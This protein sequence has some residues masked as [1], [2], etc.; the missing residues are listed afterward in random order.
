MNDSL[1][2]KLPK[3]GADNYAEWL[4]PMSAHLRAKKVFRLVSGEKPCPTKDDDK[5][6]EWKDQEEVAAGLICLALEDSQLVHVEGIM[7]DPVAMWK[8]LEAFHVQK[9]P[10][11]RF[12]AFDALLS[13]RKADDETLPEL[14]SR[15]KGLHNNIKKVLPKG[16]TSNEILEELLCISLMRALPMPEYQS[17]V[18]Q[19]SMLSQFDFNTISEAFSI[20][21]TNRTKVCVIPE[22]AL[23]SSTPVSSPAAGHLPCRNC[24]PQPSPH[25]TSTPPPQNQHPY[26][27][28]QPHIPQQQRGRGGGNRNRNNRRQRQQITYPQNANQ[29]DTT[30]GYSPSPATME[31]AGNASISP[32]ASTPFLSTD[33][34]TDTG[35]TAHMTPHRHWFASYT[36]LRVP[37]RLA[38]E[39]I[40]Y[41]AGVGSVY[42]VPI[43]SG[44]KRRAIEL[45]RVL[46]VPDLRNNLLSVFH[47]TTREG[48]IVT[49]NK[50]RVF[51]RHEGALMFTATINEGNT[52][53]LDGHVLPCSESASAASTCPMDLT[54][55]HRRF[56][57][58][59]HA[60]IQKVIREDLVTGLVIKKNSKPDPICLPCLAG[61]QSHAP[62]PRTAMFHA[63]EPGQLTHSDVHG[64]LQT[65]TPEGYRYWVTFIDDYSRYWV[66]YM[67]KSKDEVF[68]A[69]KLYQAYLEAQLGRKIKAFRN[70]KG[71]EYISSSFKSHLAACGIQLQ[72]TLRAEPHQNG[73]AERANRTLADGITAMLNEAHLPPSFWGI[74]LKAYVHVRNRLPTAG[75]TSGTPYSLFWGKKPDVSHLRVFGCIAYV[76][77]KKDQRKG[78]QSHTKKC[79]FVGYGADFKGWMF[80][81]PSTRKCIPSGSA[82]FDERYCPGTS[83]L[84]SPPAPPP[85]PLS[86]DFFYGDADNEHSSRRPAS[87]VAPAPGQGGVENHQPG[88]PA[89]DTV[90]QPLVPP[91][92]PAPAPHAPPAPALGHQRGWTPVP[93]TPQHTPPPSRPASPPPPAPPAPEP[94]YPTRDR[95]PPADWRTSVSN[96]HAHRDPTPAIGDSESSE[97]EGEDDD[98]QSEVSLCAQV[99]QAVLHA[100]V[101][102]D[103]PLSHA[104]DFGFAMHAMKA[105]MSSSE[106]RTFAQAMRRPDRDKWFDCAAKEIQSLLDN[107]TWELTKLPEGR[108]AIGSRWV[109]KI[110]RNAD[111]SIDRYKGRVVAKG[112]SQ[113]PGFD[114]TE[115]YAPT[116]KWDAIR[117]I[118]AIAALE[119]LE[120]ESVDISS[121][122][123]NGDLDAE[124]YMQQPEGFVQRG[125]EWVCKLLKAIYGLKQ[126]G[127][128]WHLKLD[129]VFKEMGFTR[130]QSDH[131]IWI[132]RK[133]DTRIIIPVF[134]DD[135]TIA[136]KDKS[137]IAWV[138]SELAKRFK[139]HDLGPTS[140][141]LGVQIQRD[142][143]KRTVTLSQRQYILDM[144]KHYNMSDATPVHTPM[145]PGIKL[146]T[147]MCPTSQEEKDAMSRVPYANAVGALMWLAVA[148]RPD[149]AYAVGVLARFNSNPGR[150][151]W[152]A[153]KH[154]FRYLCGTIDLV[155][156]IGPDPNST[157]LF[158]TYSDADHGGNPDNGHSTTGWV[159]KVGSGPIAW[160]SKLQSLVTLSTTEAEFVAAVTAGQQIIWLRNLLSEFGYNFPSPSTLHIDNMSAVSVA[161]N[162]EHHGRMKHL[163]LR[164]FWLREAVF[165]GEISVSHVPTKLMPA[166]ILT[167]PLGRNKTKDCWGL[168]GMMKSGASSGGSVG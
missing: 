57:H 60:D 33:W 82:Q 160:S 161:K 79:I 23:K 118:L 16:M 88:E 99:V 124:V 65:Q 7:H 97:G 123:L 119:N 50:N 131:S 103:V 138:K 81:D 14:T 107:G 165:E 39:S 134:V 36:P 18:S 49:V 139:L 84:Q 34:N 28:P 91:F 140:W 148:T 27:Q 146:S 133:D 108:K 17:F 149:I 25:Q 6:A 157:E 22:T 68:E 83:T 31:F 37:I 150:Q 26:Q 114:F 93:E 21:H 105:S 11:S 116:A 77:V 4:P 43:V 166:D 130:I 122:Y 70:D 75:T 12:V 55:W 144:L 129:K 168:L 38:D 109:F 66:I 67:L 9:R 120:L 1:G 32:S 61:G 63:T 51:F 163:D 20:E 143:T 125:P 76:H 137:S 156:T 153:V 46:H 58:R 87:D 110:K 56:A 151:H 71:G 62:I 24:H 101:G 121:A 89:A 135:M 126:S 86:Y 111:G 35:A 162:P 167:K 104:L 80:Y 92:P 152:T 100:G 5:I 154:V 115:T 69:F 128:M 41:S 3:L 64:P 74:A 159:V 15:L 95:R 113:R 47:L 106:P 40:V 147:S 30:P 45:K 52:G 141:L 73:V 85:A 29:A 132:W 54:L 94:R 13:A 155:P 42:F 142:R 72:Q 78:L 8:V 53:L 127:R 48:Y 102:D 19:T 59:N 96:A 145:N 90:D 117:L 10:T 2:A 136:A 44:L 98:A 112:Y 158:T 164:F